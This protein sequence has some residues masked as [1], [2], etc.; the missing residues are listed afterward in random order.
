MAELYRDTDLLPDED[1]N[2]A[3]EIMNT[4]GE[5][6][7]YTR[8]IYLGGRTPEQLIGSDDE[9]QVRVVWRSIKGLDVS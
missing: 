3:R 1:P 5:E 6:W 2:L 8:N 7:L 9:F 4:I